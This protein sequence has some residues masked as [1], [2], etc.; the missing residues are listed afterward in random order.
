MYNLFLSYFQFE[1]EPI[2]KNPKKKS[3]L[4]SKSAYTI[5]KTHINRPASNNFCFLY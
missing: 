5:K 3:H 1:S 4:Q 2:K